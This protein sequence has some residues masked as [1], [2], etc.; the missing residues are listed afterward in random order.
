MN[1]ICFR[2]SFDVIIQWRSADVSVCFL[3]IIW[4]W[5]VRTFLNSPLLNH[6][7]SN[8]RKIANRLMLS[9]KKSKEV[10]LTDG[11]S[12]LK[13]AVK[14]FEWVGFMLRVACCVESWPITIIGYGAVNHFGFT[15]LKLSCFFLHS[16]FTS[17]NLSV[18]VPLASKSKNSIF[19]QE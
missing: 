6:G 19:A 7:D 11:Q 1:E 4:P 5:W 15:W 17:R 18:I 10:W 12:H 16:S 2:I 13:D 9:Y 8:S 3:T 14:K